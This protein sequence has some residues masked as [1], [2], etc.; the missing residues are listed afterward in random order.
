MNRSR[1]TALLGTSFV[2]V[3]FILLQLFQFHLRTLIGF[4]FSKTLFGFSFFIFVLFAIGVAMALLHGH[5]RNKSKS[6][7]VL[8]LFIFLLIE[9]ISVWLFFVLATSLLNTS[10]SGTLFLVSLYI[11]ASGAAGYLSISISKFASAKTSD[12]KAVTVIKLLSVT[13]AIISFIAAAATALFIWLA[14]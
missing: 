12:Q 2:F 14:S 7:G 6:F 4:P 3:M 5:L 8:T 13:S 10:L 1:F 11:P 9:A